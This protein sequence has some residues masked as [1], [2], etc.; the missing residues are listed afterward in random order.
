M[1]RK[2]AGIVFA[3]QTGFGA[4]SGKPNCKILSNRYKS[5]D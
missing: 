3:R 5:L 4:A 2:N 1:V